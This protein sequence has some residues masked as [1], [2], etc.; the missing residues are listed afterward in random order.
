MQTLQWHNIF[1]EPTTTATSSKCLETFTYIA[2][3]EAK[4]GLLFLWLEHSHE[5]AVHGADGATNDIGAAF[6]AAYLVT[7]W[8]RNTVYVV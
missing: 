8:S 2:T 4:L 5:R 7:T 6:K 1:G 3:V